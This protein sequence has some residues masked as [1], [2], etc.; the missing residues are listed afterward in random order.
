MVISLLQNSPVKGAL[1]ENLSALD[2][3]L[4][5]AENGS[6]VFLPELFN[7]SYLLS[8]EDLG[9]GDYQ[10]TIDWMVRKAQSGHF[11][12]AG[13][14]PVMAG[15]K[16]YN[17]WLGIDEKGNRYIYDKTHLFVPGGEGRGYEAGK[18]VKQ[19]TIQ[20]KV[21]R[22]LICYD[23]RFP[24][25][26]FQV[27]DQQYDVL[28]YAANWPAPRIEQWKQLLKARAIEN[29]AYVVGVNRVGVDH[30][31]NVYPGA[32]MVVDYMGSVLVEM[33]ENAGMTSVSIDLEAMHRYRNKFP[34]LQDACPD[35]LRLRG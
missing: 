7:T 24:Y 19:F 32:S 5:S 27:P 3:L 31:G 28:V 15:E 20:D 1:D 13:S 25:V 9:P 8:P 6:F 12:I 11:I 23:L 16:M 34:F 17:R 29:Q 26:S 35:L 33:D 4:A 22:P 2:Q 14:I 30:Y 10:K 21:V 18:E